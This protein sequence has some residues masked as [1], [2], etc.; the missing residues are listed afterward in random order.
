MGVEDPVA[1]T[2][3][4]RQIERAFRNAL[5]VLTQRIELFLTLLLAAI[6]KRSRQHN[7]ITLEKKCLP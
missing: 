6:D 5:I 4:E 2:G 1:V 7:W 3:D